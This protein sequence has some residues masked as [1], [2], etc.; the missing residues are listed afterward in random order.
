MPAGWGAARGRC[1]RVGGGW[2]CSSAS[3]AARH[4][5]RAPGCGWWCWRDGGAES[6]VDSRGAAAADT[7]LQEQST[8][9]RT[10][11]RGRQVKGAAGGA[12]VS[13]RASR[14]R[15]AFPLQP[16]RRSLQLALQV[17]RLAQDACS[18]DQTTTQRAR[19]RDQRRDSD[20]SFPSLA[21]R[22]GGQAGPPAQ[23]ERHPLGRSSR[24]SSAR[25]RVRSGEG[26][27]GPG[28]AADGSAPHSAHPSRQSPPGGA[29]QGPSFTRSAD[30]WPRA[31]E[32]ASRGHRRRSLPFRVQRLVTGGFLPPRCYPPEGLAAA[33]K[34]G[35]TVTVENPR[36]GNGLG[37]SQSILYS[38]EHQVVSLGTAAM[39]R[40]CRER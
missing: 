38:I 20:E 23:A 36:K 5:C 16:L 40:I 6:E 3:L 39:R 32:E 12:G 15:R 27:R 7:A 29:E 37:P 18:E 4:R 30:I 11:R 8:E 19:R 2:R 26:R 21:E 33:R 22:R 17:E 25:S 35:G 9:Q 34:V 1:L 24:L 28:G 14:A 31:R 10:R 13:A